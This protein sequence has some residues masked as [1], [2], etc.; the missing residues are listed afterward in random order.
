MHLL[1]LWMHMLE[2]RLCKHVNMYIML[3]CPAVA[4]VCVRSVASV[5]VVDY[6][7]ELMLC[8]LWTFGDVEC[9]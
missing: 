8:W 1:K 2:A 3:I 5:C 6:L 7:L 4:A 9:F